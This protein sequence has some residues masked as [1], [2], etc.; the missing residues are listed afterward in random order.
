MS[1]VCLCRFVWMRGEI[2]RISI[3]CPTHNVTSDEKMA[4]TAAAASREP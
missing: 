2:V 4:L 3:E 1:S